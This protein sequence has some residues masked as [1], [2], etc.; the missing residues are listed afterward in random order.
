MISTIEQI[1]NNQN[2][3]KIKSLIGIDKAIF[4]SLINKAFRLLKISIT[5][6]LI[7]RCLTPTEQGYWYTFLS[8][9]TLTVFAEMGFLNI[10]NQFISHEFAYLTE[11]NDGSISGPNEKIERF[12]S[13]IHFVLKF[14][15]FIIP[16]A[17]CL[18]ISIGSAFLKHSGTNFSIILAWIMYSF[19]GAITL[20]VSLCSS[21]LNGCNKVA[22]VQKRTFFSLLINSL[23]IWAALLF[24]FKLWGLFVGTLLNIISSIILFYSVSP[25]LW[26]QIFQSKPLKQF[27]WFSE[28]LPL[29][30]RYALSWVSGYFI[31]QFITP[32]TMFYAGA[33][34]AGRMGLSISFVWA[35]MTAAN[36]WPSTKTPLFNMLIAKN[37]RQNLDKLF[38]IT[39]KQSILAFCTGSFLL[40]FICTYLF[41][42]FH[43]DTR[44]L[45][46][47][48]IFLLIIIALISLIVSNWAIYLRAH[49][50]EPYVWLSVVSAI[51]NGMAIWLSMK[52]S[53]AT[54]VTIWSYCIVSLI[55][56]IP[57]RFVFITKRKE[58]SE[59]SNYMELIN[60]D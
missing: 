1:I 60:N 36:L 23:G 2:I 6:Y 52:F 19:T 7:I 47:L 43:W 21:I 17:F 57:C 35:V 11:N 25:N 38:N 53:A 58:Y 51:L 22:E 45:S 27:N 29:Q 3:K 12:I 40:L 10:I 55:M 56:L 33:E 24:G 4:F 49:K 9:G 42:I 20:L 28:T 48:E 26:K 54:T 18:L 46:P 37:E 15:S 44:I 14:Y 32:A 50:Q 59:F 5:T 13:F 31:F 8:L 34:A 39:L 41:P 16:I 30:W